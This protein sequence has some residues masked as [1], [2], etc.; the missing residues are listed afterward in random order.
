MSTRP[1][2]GRT[3]ATGILTSGEVFDPASRQWSPAAPLLTARHSHTATL[4]SNGKVLVA[5]GYNS[6]RFLSSAEIVP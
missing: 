6:S 3:C 1:P 4:L 5:G 2:I